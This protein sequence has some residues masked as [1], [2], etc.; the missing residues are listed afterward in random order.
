MKKHLLASLA[1]G[2]MMLTNCPNQAAAQSRDQARNT[3]AAS[4]IPWFTVQ[5]K[6]IVLQSGSKTKPLDKD[7]TLPNGI[8]VD[9]RTQSIV[10]TNGKRVQMKE[11]DLL[12]LN[13]EFMQK[14][15]AEADAPPPTA[16][17]S[18]AAAVPVLAPEAAPAAPAIVPFSYQPTAPVNGKL[19]AAVE[20]GATGLSAF[21]IRVDGNHNWKLE[22]TDP[23]NT[24]AMN[25]PATE[26]RSALAR[27]I[28][29]L[30]ALGVSERDIHFI[31]SAETALLPAPQRLI[32]SLEDL[33]YPVT[34]VTPECEGGLGLRAALPPGFGQKA[35]VLDLGA[36][37]T[38]IAWLEDDEP[39]AVATY[40]A[41]D[42][43]KGPDASMAADIK[44]KAELV[45]TAQ[46][47]TC[48]VLGS[49]PAVLA[50]TARQ[51]QE[52]YTI[53]QAATTY[54]ATDAKTKASLSIYQT[55]A[56]TTGCQQF[57]FA[58]DSNF[59]IGYLLSLP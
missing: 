48:F 22:K 10:F 16:V 54:A 51:G 14:A 52:P 19:K 59:A 26:V 31:A 23:D 34:A 28:G 8:R 15:T 21:V 32:K 5:N 40:G 25:G 29:G 1:L 7:V 2:G 41:Q 53:L 13:G 20:I 4:F 46:R 27:Y 12:N 24:A 58:Y 3:P 44:N 39:K 35:F 11:R 37:N 36:A 57:V 38:K 50:K 47:A 55:V 43:A 33:K 49:M 9:Y 56:A 6:A 18:A 17:A 30:V 42:L 45:P